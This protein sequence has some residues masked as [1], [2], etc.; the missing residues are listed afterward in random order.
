M[1][2]W[3]PPGE[4]EVLVVYESPHGMP[5]DGPGIVGFPFVTASVI[6]KTEKMQRT[7]CR[8]LLPHYE[9]SFA[10]RLGTVGADGRSV[11]KSLSTADLGELY[12][13]IDRAVAIPTPAGYLL[14]IPEPAIRHDD[15]HRNC[16]IDYTTD[17]GAPR[18]WTRDQLAMLLHWLPADDAAKPARDRLEKLVGALEWRDHFRGWYLYAAAGV[19][20]LIFTRWGATALIS[21]GRR[22]ETFFESLKKMLTVFLL[23]ALFWL[24]WTILTDG[25]GC[26]GPMP[27][28]LR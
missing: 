12:R 2:A 7:D 10:K 17:G 24:L 6:C 19:A 1:S 21:P 20:G 25:N 5:D 14:E 28:R 4:Y 13:G 22:V 11:D 8:I 16:T 15:E 27:F 23:S 26:R 18:E 9:H 3:L